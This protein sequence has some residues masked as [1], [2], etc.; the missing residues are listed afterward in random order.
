MS[1]YLTC[2]RY[3]SGLCPRRGDRTAFVALSQANGGTQVR[4]GSSV[5]SSVGLGST[6]CVTLGVA[7][8]V[9]MFACRPARETHASTP[10][11]P[12]AI[13]DRQMA[14]YNRHDVNGLLAGFDDSSGLFLFGEPGVLRTRAAMRS[15]F[16]PMFQTYP[17][18]HTETSRR[19]IVG[20]FVVDQEQLTGIANGRPTAALAVYEVRNEHLVNY[21]QTLVEGHARSVPY[22]APEP[23]AA[24]TMA[25][26]IAALNQ[27]DAAAAAAAYGDTVVEH[28]FSSD[29]AVTVLTRDGMRAKFESMFQRGGHVHVTVENQ[30]V[31]GSYVASEEHITGLPD[32]GPVDRLVVVHV[33]DNH[34]VADWHGQ[35]DDACGSVAGGT[36]TIIESQDDREILHA[37]P[38]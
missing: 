32:G 37:A 21:W 12:D 15:T 5:G 4:T 29:T 31:V 34:I 13:V 26:S 8:C 9:T 1:S 14:A 11:L 22:P 3:S 25:R 19:I 7:L 2:K 27:H 17:N 38:P 30:L 24:S 18:V 10:T 23:G 28:S 16:A 6:L 33:A 35:E 36:G 20:P